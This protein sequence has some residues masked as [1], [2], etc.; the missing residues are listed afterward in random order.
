MQT[1]NNS[2]IEALRKPISWL[3]AALVLCAALFTVPVYFESA[4]GETLEMVG[5]CL[6]ILAALGRVWCSVYIAGRKDR[7]LCKDGPYAMS[8]NPLY[9]FSFLGVIGA[10]AALQ[11]LSI[12]AFS[13]GCFLLYYFFVIRS[14]EVRL[15]RLFGEPYSDY[16]K[17]TPRFFPLWKFVRS[18]ESY[19]INPR[20]IERE[21][22]DVIWFLLAIVMIE[23]L[24]ES[25]RSGHMVFAV[26]PF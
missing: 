19:S 14:E 24:E 16:S 13:A 1:P 21:L 15:S 5:Y 22:R 12:M 2:I 23:I 8:R 9:F 25:H 7:V 26:M 6:L 3:A 18:G 4:F 20:V 11:S 10:S 17:C